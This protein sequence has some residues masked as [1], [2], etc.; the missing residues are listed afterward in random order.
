VDVI[1]TSA[2]GSLA[3]A[4]QTLCG[5][6]SSEAACAGG[7]ALPTGGGVSRLVLSSAEPGNHALIVY[8]T[9]DSPVTLK[10]AFR[11]PQAPPQNETCGTAADLAPGV[12]TTARV[13]GAL[14]DTSSECGGQTGDLVYRFELA[15]AQDINLYATSLDGL[16][17]PVLS[18]RGDD[19]ATTE[20]TC[21]IGNNAHVFWR[22]LA[23]THYVAVSATGP[24]DMSLTLELDPLSQ[25][26]ADD[27]CQ[28]A[29]PLVHD[30]TVQ[31]PLSSHVDDLHLGCLSGAP[32]AAYALDL[33][34]RSDVMLVSQFSQG[35][36]V[37]VSLAGLDCT[38]TDRLSCAVSSLSPV[39]SSLHAVAAGSYRAVVESLQ[40]NPTTL[41]ALVRAA[42][43]AVVVPFA[44]SCADAITIPPEGGFFQGNTA[45]A[46]SDY[47]AGC[48]LGG[49]SSG[50]RDQMLKIVLTERKRVVLDMRGSAYPTLLAVHRG[51]DCPGTEVFQGCSAGYAQDRS[52]LDLTLDPGEYF[53]QIDGYAGGEGMWFLDAYVVNP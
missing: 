52:F 18:L 11:T 47:D 42:L 1:A 28:S 36:T 20:R 49:Q 29:P 51:P 22:A 8:S 34:E 30:R 27:T 16:G 39:R 6:A 25:A 40:A 9:A 17:L 48:D 43:P 12:A 21:N 24:T 53:I 2:N 41:T 5:D 38:A 37:A 23:G 14:V 3:L 44:D 45:N 13:S 26:P 33:A 32:D 31:V 10:V 15:Q 19:C 50:A 7:M 46:K 35:D 4:A